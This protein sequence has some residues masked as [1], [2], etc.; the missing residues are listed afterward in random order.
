MPFPIVLTIVLLIIFALLYNHLVILN[1]RVEES[2]SDINTQLKHRHDLILSLITNV[3]AHAAS[4]APVLETVAAA[5]S[6]AL[7]GGSLPEREQAENIL[8]S[9][10]N[11]LWIVTEEYPEL[12]ADTTFQHLRDELTSTENRLQDTRR[13]Y[14]LNVKALNIRL[15]QVPFNFIA[16]F[17]RLTPRDFF[18]IKDR[19][20]AEASLVNF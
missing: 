9:S 15:S 16:K 10:L 4:T 1:K 14:N 5:R 7:R 11:S 6:E 3:Q 13:F 2:L 12:Q 18:E 17:T 8:T 19:K 20:E